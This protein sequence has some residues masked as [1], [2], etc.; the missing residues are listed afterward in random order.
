MEFI[1]NNGKIDVE[2]TLSAIGQTSNQRTCTFEFSNRNSAIA[3]LLEFYRKETNKPID[4]YVIVSEYAGRII[5]WMMNGKKIGLM[6]SGGVGCGKTTFLNAICRMV[7]YLYYSNIS[8]ERRGF[9]WETAYTIVEWCGNNES[10]YNDFM[11]TEWAAIDDI[12]QESA[13][14]N[15]YGQ[16]LYPIRDI[17]LYRYE[18]NLL[19]LATTN[20]NPKDLTERYGKR[21]GD[22][23][24]E[25]FEIIVIKEDS[26][27]R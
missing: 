11:R 21:L 4:N 17:M 7:N 23:M 8:Y 15:R 6:L 13:E 20:L 18:K 16:M 2:K 14:L 1:S 22:R 10:R 24:Q 19:T 27:R 3:L 12:G 9:Q 26:Y 25:M 5:D